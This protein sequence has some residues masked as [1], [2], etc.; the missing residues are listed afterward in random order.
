M[1]LAD[2]KSEMPTG[3]VFECIASGEAVTVN[4]WDMFDQSIS[5]EFEVTL[6]NDEGES[7]GIVYAH[8]IGLAKV[9][10]GQIK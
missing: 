1:T 3:T 10:S 5:W 6:Y 2:I 7:K 9:I 4:K 8:S